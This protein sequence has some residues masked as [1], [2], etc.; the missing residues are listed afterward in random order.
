MEADFWLERWREGHTGWHRAD[1]HPLLRLHW[2]AMTAHDSHAF[3]PLC[4][5]SLDLEWLHERGHAVS[6]VE[7]S[8][9]AIA[10]FAD[11]HGLQLVPDPLGELSLHTAVR[12]RLIEGDYFALTSDTL[13][14]VDIVY[15]RAALVALPDALRPRYVQHLRR[16]AP[17]APILLVTLDYEQVRM[18]GPPFAVPAAEVQRLF[19]EHYRVELLEAVDVLASEPRFRERRLDWM[20]ETAWRLIPREHGA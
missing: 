15:D 1:V 8:G 3:V 16:L 20:I 2:P 18:A 4:G 6:G 9:V 7:L 14:D 12:Y 11:R 17:D 19:G 10:R 13:G 5:A